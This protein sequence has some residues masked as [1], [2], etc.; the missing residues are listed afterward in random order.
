MGVRNVAWARPLGAGGYEESFKIETPKWRLLPASSKTRP[1]ELLRAC[2]G[3]NQFAM[4]L[5][6]S[7][8]C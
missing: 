7:T 5:L 6:P 3:V 8:S 4:D 2:V 1:I